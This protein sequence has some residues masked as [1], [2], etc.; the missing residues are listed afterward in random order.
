MRELSLRNL[1]CWLC[2]SPF[3][4]FCV[5]SWLASVASAAAVDAPGI[6][7]LRA[8]RTSTTGSITSASPRRQTAIYHFGS[9]G[10]A[11]ALLPKGLPGDEINRADETLEPGDDT[12]DTIEKSSA[13]TIVLLGLASVICPMIACILPRFRKSDTIPLHQ[14][15]ADVPGSE[16]LGYRSTLA[17]GSLTTSTTTRLA[18]G[19]VAPPQGT[20]FFYIGEET[21]DTVEDAENADA[22]E[23]QT[24]TG[25]HSAGLEPPPTES[26]PEAELCPESNS[27]SPSHHPQTQ[28]QTVPPPVMLPRLAQP[29]ADP[30]VAALPAL[31]TAD[32]S[33]CPSRCRMLMLYASPLCR[34]D[35]RGPVQLPALC[36]E[37]EWRTIL[38]AS[39]EARCGPAAFAARALTSGAQ[40]VNR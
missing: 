5:A 8:S 28:I 39:A 3:L 16:V 13:G 26:E 24:V 15:Y 32:G 36:F 22:T 33:K 38:T 30:A 40:I 7:R 19:L 9:A 37:K 11:S 35:L 17:H 14:G 2:P 31:P 34:T 10:Y 6:L 12:M 20:Q 1:L 27:A 4:W 25:F 23:S 29:V 18:A 21:V